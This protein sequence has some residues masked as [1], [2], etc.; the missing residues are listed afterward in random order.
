MD[1]SFEAIAV[2][3]TQ[4]YHLRNEDIVLCKWKFNCTRC[5]EGGKLYEALG[6]SCEKH[7]TTK[8]HINN[9]PPGQTLMRAPHGPWPRGPLVLWPSADTLSHLNIFTPSQYYVNPYEP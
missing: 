5:S 3:M 2:L 6:R 4:G 9:R 7:V 1:Y 8:A